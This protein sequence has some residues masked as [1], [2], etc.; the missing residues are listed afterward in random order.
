M[1]NHL[2]E[3]PFAQWPEESCY[4]QDAGVSICAV[5]RTCERRARLAERM[6]YG[7]AFL[8]GVQ[9][10]RDAVASAPWDAEN[11]IAHAQRAADLAAIDSLKEE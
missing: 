3:C 5:I 2:P 1:N 6:E 7:D 8:R 9:A 11:W 10:A 4:Q